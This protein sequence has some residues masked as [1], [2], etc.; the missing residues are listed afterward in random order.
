MLDAIVAQPYRRQ[1]ALQAPGIG[2]APA[3]ALGA[4]APLIARGSRLAPKR[5]ALAPP[6]QARPVTRLQ[7]ALLRGADAQPIARPGKERRD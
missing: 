2:A 5:L 3:L 6:P 1:L 4:A 7:A